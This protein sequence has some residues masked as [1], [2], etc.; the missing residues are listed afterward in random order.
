MIFNL[1]KSHFGEN[2]WIWT[3]S[4]PVQ[5]AESGDDWMLALPVSGK[6]T[7]LAG[8]PLADICIVAGGMPGDDG[9]MGH[10][11]SSKGGNGGGIYEQT[12][13]SI[14]AGEYNITVGGSG[15]NS[16]VAGPTAT[17]TAVSGAGSFGGGQPGSSSQ[18]G[19]DGVLAWNDIDTLLN[20][21]W[22]YGAGGGKG[23]FEGRYD[24]NGSKPGGSVGDAPHD[25]KSGHGGEDSDA[26][27]YQLQ[28]YSGAANTGQ[29]GGGGHYV[30]YNG[31]DY[32]WNG[33][34]GGSGIILIR[35]HK[36]VT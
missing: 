25:A 34:A 8:I 4:E 29:G 27:G 31:N 32:T 5:W 18:T 2:K 23:D 14:P 22:L 1:N 24:S 19:A 26:T 21:G 10:D 7:I 3:G 12:G 16:V 15:Q 30:W 9:L 28:G 6:F 20:P 33:G 13:I 17:W 11:P 35:K 36:E